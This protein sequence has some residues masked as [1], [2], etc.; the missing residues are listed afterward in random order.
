MTAQLDISVVMPTFQR[1]DVVAASVK[2]LAAQEG[3]ESFEVVV[4]VDGSTDGTAEA[5]RGLELPF[6]LTVLEQANE[7]S[8]A[9]RNRGAAAARGELLLFLDDDMEADPRL[10]A[11]HVRSHR[12][13]ADVVFGHIPLHPESPSSFLSA[14]VGT[15]AE[16]RLTSLRARDGQLEIT[17]FLT[18]QMSLRRDLFERLGGFDTA[19]TRGGTFGGADYDFG[20][21]LVNAGYT[22]AFNPDAISRQRYLVT[23]RRY[24]RQW[25]DNG[26]ARVMLVR[27]Y[28][29][30]ATRLLSQR[31]RRSDR[32]L[33]RWLRAPLRGV[34]L[35]LL[36]RR[37]ESGWAIRWFWRVQ[38][39]EFFAGVHAAGGVPAP[40][41]VRVLCYHAIS[42]L[43]S[44]QRMAPYGLP[45]EQ[46]SRQLRLLAWRFRFLDAA[47]FGRFLEG[48]GV[49]RRA[50]LLTFD[51]CYRSLLEAGLPLLRAHQA[52][53][54]AFAV[55]SLVGR[56][57]E[58][59]AGNG[60]VALPLL[61][62]DGLRALERGE[63]AIGA[64]TQTHP[65][66]DTLPPDRVAHEIGGAISDLEAMGLRRPALLAY[67]YGAHN[68]EV[69]RAAAATGL[70]G[71][72]TTVPGLARPGGDPHAIPRIEIVREDGTL[73][74]I[75]KVVTGRRARPRWARR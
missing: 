35:A 48:G 74:F 28:P 65:M 16:E 23:P 59:T 71:A 47:E 38:A 7:G 50:M 8:A 67:P 29:D 45:P 31:E 14:T 52:P 36:E 22:M 37:P 13:G 26:R 70:A 56:T 49:P 15:W 24:L 75:W 19:F 61:D 34:V 44:S 66:L 42:D 2:A 43:S 32:Y 55:T 68:P 73:R 4:V 11:E 5:L 58:W 63:V 3:D 30:Q 21:R 25:R 33:W 40:R 41:P 53:A 51:D 1:R 9:A 6:P 10:V 39:L 27:R 17:D 64:H 54:V 69:V 18:G 46:F 20:R 60:G 62:V 12:Q 72:F 57:S